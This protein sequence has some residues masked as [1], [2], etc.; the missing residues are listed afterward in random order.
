MSPWFSGERHIPAEL[1][2]DRWQRKSIAIDARRAWLWDAR[3]RLQVSL[4]LALVGVLGLLGVMLFRWLHRA[5]GWPDFTVPL[6]LYGWSISAYL[7]FLIWRE[8]RLAK[9]VYA[10][11][12]L[13][14]H[15]VCPRCGYLRRGLAKAEPCPECATVVSQESGVRA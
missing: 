3:T 11:L 7:L 10:Q 6:F 13:R 5:Q 2:L 14:G 12:R 4:W 9:C 1:P 8:R 15:D